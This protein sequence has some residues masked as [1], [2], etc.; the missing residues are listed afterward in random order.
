MR[1]DTIFI[2]R[3]KELLL[4]ESASLQYEGLI[5]SSAGLWR[6]YT[7]MQ[8]VAPSAVTIAV[9]TDAMICIMNLNVSFLVMVL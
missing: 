5:P 3:K 1:Y 9:A 8:L 7:P 6:G 4:F 2:E